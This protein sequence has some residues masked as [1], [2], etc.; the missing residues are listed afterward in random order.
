MAHIGFTGTQTGM[1]IRQ[2]NK[3]RKTLQAFFNEGSV[4]FHHGDCIGADEQ[5]HDIAEEIGFK[6]IIHPPLNPKKRAFKNPFIARNPKDY[7]DR[8][9]DIVDETDILIG[10]P[11]EIEEQIRS[12]TWSTIRRAIKADR[13]VILLKPHD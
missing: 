9:Q 3:L 1:T 8:N 7:M 12:G 4:Y 2:R 10:A 5:A 6:V 11:K 13:E